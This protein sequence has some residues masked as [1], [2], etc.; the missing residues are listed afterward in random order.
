MK[1][2]EALSQLKKEKSRLARLI[3]LRK[4][5]VFVEKGKKTSFDPKSLSKEIDEKIEEIRKLKVNIQKTNFNTLIVE[6]NI[7]LAEGIIKIGDIRSRISQLFNLFE[8]KSSWIYR[9][10]EEK[11]MIPQL[12]ELEVD[13]EIERLEK[14]KAE[15]DN[16]IQITNWNAELEM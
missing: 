2:G 9:E 7:T 10:K 6:S 1:I 3:S 16:N 12:S 4:E 8:R 13:R 14:E 11:E 5:N 15:L